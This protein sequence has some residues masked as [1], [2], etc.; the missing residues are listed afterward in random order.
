ML[1]LIAAVFYPTVNGAGVVL[2][3]SNKFHRMKQIANKVYWRCGKYKTYGCRA[4][5][6]T[7]GSVIN[8]INDTHTHS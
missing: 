1:Y 4:T 5:L 7:I 2:V 3:G 8:I 6:H